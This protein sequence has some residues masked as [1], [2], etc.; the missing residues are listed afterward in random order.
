MG[1]DCESAGSADRA[2]HLEIARPELIACL[3]VGGCDVPGPVHSDR[4]RV[5]TKVLEGLPEQ[6]GEGRKPCRRAADDRQHQREPVAGGAN[7]RL[8]AAAHTD[9]DRE[10]AGFGVRHDVLVLERRSGLPVP[11]DRSALE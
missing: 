2:D 8:R 7:D 3:L 6:L 10:G 5:S 4:K 1:G 11:G 9:P